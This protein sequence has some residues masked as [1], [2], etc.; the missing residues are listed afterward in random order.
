MNYLSAENIGRNL[1]ERWL[2][3]N[4]TFGIL[5]GERVALIGANGSGKSSL[6]DMIVG[7]TDIDA[8]Q[9]SVRKD[10]RTGYLDQSPDLPAG[11]TVLETIFASQNALTAAIK[12]YEL[13]LNLHDDKRL[14]DAIERVDTLKAWDYEVKVKQILAKLGITDFDKLIGNLSGGQQKRVALA[15]VLIEEPDFLILD[16][17][18]NHLDLDTIEWLEGY[19]SSSN[20]TLLLVTHDRY[21]LDKVSNRILELADNQIYKYTG[22]YNYYLE[23]KEA[24][25][26]VNAATQKNYRNLLRKELEWMRRQPKARGT[27]SQSRI[28][29]F[30]D[31][32]DKTVKKGPEEKLELSMKMERMGSKIIEINHVSKAFDTHKVIEE[33]SYTFKRGDRIGIVGKNGMGKTTLLEIITEKVKPDMGRV[34]KGETIKIG[35]YSQEGLDFKDDQRVIDV[36]REIAEYVKMAD[37][38]ELSISN[39]LTLFLFPPAMQY[40]FVHKLSGG[41]KRRLQ[42]LKILVQNPNFLILDEPTNDLDISTLNVLEDFLMNFGGCLLVVSHD[43]YFMDKIV[44]H[45]FVFEGKGYIRDFPGNYT[46][47]RNWKDEQPEPETEGAAAT[48]TQASPTAAPKPEVKRKLSYKEQK[49]YEGLEKELEKLEQTKAQLLENMNSG[50]G[51]HEQLAQ[52]AKEFENI[53]ETIAEKEMRWLELSEL[54]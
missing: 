19:L 18:T 26:A 28:D 32:K 4:L 37:G 43:R 36:V 46:D 49:E 8:G 9:I 38:T 33:F 24:Q 10:I 54:A 13:A 42:L 31:L 16:E 1:G 30:Y 40:S 14:A 41:E 20:I 25:E 22:N 45:L 7:K 34:V 3:R 2:F 29:A 17:P 35:Y 6:L 53:N 48:K 5:Q 52:W 39:F 11:K 21:F 51:S 50:G 47:Y 27:K 23:K 15:R 44:E 12:E